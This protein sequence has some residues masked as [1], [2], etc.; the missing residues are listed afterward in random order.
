MTARHSLALKAVDAMVAWLK[1]DA[2]C[3]R[4]GESLYFVEGVRGPARWRHAR[5]DA[6]ECHPLCKHCGQPG[7]YQI[8][9]PDVDGCQWPVFRLSHWECASCAK[10]KLRIEHL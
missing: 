5:T 8:G 4:C 3:P 7:I 10:G 9:Q 1:S 2:Q 6:V